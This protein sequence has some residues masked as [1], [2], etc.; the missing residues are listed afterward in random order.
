MNANTYTF[1]GRAPELFAC[2]DSFRT[3]IHV[4]VLLQCYSVPLKEGD[5]IVAGTDGVWDNL[6]DQE[7]AA[8]VSQTKSKG[9]NPGDTAEALARFAHIRYAPSRKLHTFVSGQPSSSMCKAA[10][11]RAECHARQLNSFTLGCSRRLRLAGRRLAAPNE[12]SA[13]SATMMFAGVETQRQSPH[14]P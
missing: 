11:A 5:I 3:G 8:L 7:C 12:R 6:F 10:D 9:Q 13:R 4:D 14:S 1:C 2:S